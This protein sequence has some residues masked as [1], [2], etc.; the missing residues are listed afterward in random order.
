MGIKTWDKVVLTWD[1]LHGMGVSTSVCLDGKF[2]PNA[3]DPKIFDSKAE[4]QV[5]GLFQ[6]QITSL[7]RER[8]DGQRK[9]EITLDIRRKSGPNVAPNSKA[10]VKFLEARLSPR[11][12]KRPLPN[13]YGVSI[14]PPAIKSWVDTKFTLNFVL[15]NSEQFCDTAIEIGRG[16]F[17]ALGIHDENGIYLAHFTLKRESFVM[18]DGS[19]ITFAHWLRMSHRLPIWGP[20][21]HS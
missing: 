1:C 19:W 18:I 3:T 2:K 13:E 14:Q 12:S 7:P 9:G 21:D 6:M 4:E 16:I 17:E 8:D 20:E 11:V 5:H 15:A 10:L